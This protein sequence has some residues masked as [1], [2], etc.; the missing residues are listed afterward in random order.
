MQ[1]LAHADD[2]DAARQVV[3]RRQYAAPK[4]AAVALRADKEVVLAAVAQHGEALQYAMP[5]L[6]QHAALQQIK[7]LSRHWACLTD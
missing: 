1:E 6:A 2:I 7:Q 5:A 4:Y 3:Q